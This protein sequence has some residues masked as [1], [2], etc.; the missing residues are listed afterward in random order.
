MKSTTSQTTRILSHLLRRRNVWCAMYELARV[1]SGS[2]NGF[3][4]VHSRIADLRKRGY[5]ITNKIEVLNRVQC[6]FY[7]LTK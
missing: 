4:M 7:R 5:S 1:G 2:K 3:C 6:S